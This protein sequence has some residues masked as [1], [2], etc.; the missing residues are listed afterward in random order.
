ML[1]T[2]IAIVVIVSQLTGAFV[3]AHTEVGSMNTIRLLKTERPVSGLGSQ[4]KRTFLDF[5]V[6]GV[7]LYERIGRR[8]D[9]IS[10][11]WKDP[12]M[13]REEQDKAIRRLLTLDTGDLPNGRVSLYVCPECGDLGCGVISALINVADNQITWRDFGYENNYEENVERDSYSSVGPFHFNR[14]DYQATLNLKL[15]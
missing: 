13:S 14:S 1:P 4:I 7:C 9:L 2:R 5:V 6:D 12:P 11:L 8:S 15:P 3:A 10:T